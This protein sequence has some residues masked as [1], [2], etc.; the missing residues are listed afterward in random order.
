MPTVHYL[1]W[2]QAGDENPPEREF[3]S[4][5]HLADQPIDTVPKSWY[6]EITSVPILDV[7]TVYKA[8]QGG[9]PLD[10][11]KYDSPDD[12]R[13]AKRSFQEAQTRSMSI[14]DIIEIDGRLFIVRLSGIGFSELNWGDA[15]DID[16]LMDD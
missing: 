10:P 16:A 11:K 1:N 3:F 8:F 14:G 15:P 5:L 4:A 13:D 6:R 7:E 12:V 2:D 9:V